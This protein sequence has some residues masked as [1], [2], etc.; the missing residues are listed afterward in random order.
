MKDEKI[1]PSTNTYQI[2]L[3]LFGPTQFFSLKLLNDSDHPCETWGG[4]RGLVSVES[5]G[6]WSVA[7]GLISRKNYVFKK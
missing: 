5:V 2:E 4:L 7:L 3:I 6:E 1:G